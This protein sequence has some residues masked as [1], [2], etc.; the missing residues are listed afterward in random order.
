MSNKVYS[1]IL[2]LVCTMCLFSC[3]QTSNQTASKRA[4][5]VSISDESIT[6]SDNN[7]DALDLQIKVGEQITYTKE[8]KANQETSLLSL[9]KTNSELNNDIALL[10]AQNDGNVGVNLSLP[11]VFD[12]TIVFHLDMNDVPEYSTKVLSGK[13]ASL[14]G[15]FD[16]E[17]I[18]SDI[19]KW[20]YRKN[21][22]NVGE[23]TI[24]NMRLYLKELNSSDYKQYVTS[25]EIPIITS[26][27]GINYKLSSD[28]VADN[29]YLFACKFEKDLEDFV[30]EKVSLK[31]EGAVHSLSQPISC[32]R[33]AESSGTSCIFLVGI[34]NDWNYSVA[35][36]GLISIDDIKPAQLGGAR[37]V[38]EGDLSRFDNAD[39]LFQRNKIIIR[40]PNQVP[41]VT[42]FANLLTREWS[43]NGISCNVNFEVIF[44][45]DIKSITLLREDHLAKW[46]G[47]G[48]KEIDLQD[49]TSPYLFSYEL[50]LE[51]GDNYVPVIVTDLRGNKMEFQYNVGCESKPNNTPQINIDNNVN[52][53]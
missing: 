6:I 28:L 1:I 2:G 52:V 13:C 16:A 42:G 20:L 41:C 12:T 49:K 44:S 45:G 31:F 5:T 23:E 7:K 27:N 32:N 21:L 37:R 17:N 46:L 47:K 51:D 29:Y 10:L 9:L 38:S 8:V 48:K 34:N 53:N 40:M 25:E 19:I 14:T 36:V 30:E 43:G 3:D 39:L 22:K 24:N 4:T 11:N 18:E 35:P 50:H 15:V 33:F 26:F